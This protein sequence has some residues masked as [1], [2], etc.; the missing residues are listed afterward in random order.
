MNTT[1][2]PTWSFLLI[3]EK[4]SKINN[5]VRKS[6]RK[7]GK[8]QID[9][10]ANKSYRKLKRTKNK[11]KQTNNKKHREGG[12]SILLAIHHIHPRKRK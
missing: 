4:A 7:K 12:F 1:T 9:P 10:K 5:H 11:N 3:Y 8:D 6:K 2:T